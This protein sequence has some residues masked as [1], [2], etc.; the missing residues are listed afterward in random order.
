[1]FKKDKDNGNRFKTI[2]KQGNLTT[3]SIIVDT[4]T[5]VNYMFC[6]QGYAGG[7]TVLLDKDG[8]PVISPNEK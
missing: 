5:G 7:L 8:K 3:Y 2:Y 6:G 4:E 1:M